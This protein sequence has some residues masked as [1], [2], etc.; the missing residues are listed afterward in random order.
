M[1]PSV[2]GISNA[3]VVTEARR[4]RDNFTDDATAHRGTVREG[5]SRVDPQELDAAR[6]DLAD[7]GAVGPV[8]G[9]RLRGRVHNGPNP[10]A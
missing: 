9:V 4:I 10:D 5:A 2:L 3:R 7:L 8:P 6:V 1:T